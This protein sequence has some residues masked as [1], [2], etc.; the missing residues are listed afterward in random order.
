MFA[1]AE[2]A[3]RVYLLFNY[4]TMSGADVVKWAEK[5]IDDSDSPSNALLELAW[6]HPDNTA[7]IISVLNVLRQGADVYKSFEKI[8]GFLY[9]Y[10]KTHP[11]EAERI[12]QRLL[13]TLVTLP[14]E[15]RRR[16]FYFLYRVDDDF[17]LNIE[18]SATLKKFL[19]ELRKF[20]E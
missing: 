2:D 11:A 10:V 19:D 18:R 9:D 3:Q 7:D 1:L 17:D 15:K 14:D 5:Q 16:D 8:L 12:S 13:G 6:I 20:A 4:G